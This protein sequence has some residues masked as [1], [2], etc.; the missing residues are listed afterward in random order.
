MPDKSLIQFIL[1]GTIF[2]LAACAA[3]GPLDYGPSTDGGAGYFESQRSANKWVIGSYF[4]S[5]DQTSQQAENIVMRRAAEKGV[6]GGFKWIRILNYDTE[7]RHGL[8]ASL[9]ALDDPESAKFRGMFFFGNQDEKVMDNQLR[10]GVN[11]AQ[12]EYIEYARE[13]DCQAEKCGTL[14]F[15]LEKC[16]EGDNGRTQ[17]ISPVCN[18]NSVNDADRNFKGVI[19]ER[20]PSGVGAWYKTEDILQKYITR[21]EKWAAVQRK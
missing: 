21:S 7:R 6:Q 13:V 1:I 17:E 15:L 12:V 4:N 19:E 9:P 3:T 2:T 18:G 5:Y 8:V 14:E 16:S 11:F 20:N 10:S